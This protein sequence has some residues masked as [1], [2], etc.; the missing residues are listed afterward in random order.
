MSEFY[1][2]NRTRNL[3][4]PES[5]VNRVSYHSSGLIFSWGLSTQVGCKYGVFCASICL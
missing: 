4:D 5:D 2:L 1:K 3:Y